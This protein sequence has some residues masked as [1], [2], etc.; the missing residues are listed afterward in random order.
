MKIK[1]YSF[2]G[3]EYQI[4]MPENIMYTDERFLAHFAVESTE[5]P[6]IFNFN[7][8]EELS[9]PMGQCVTAKPGFRIYSENNTYVRYIGSVEK[10]W[11]NAYIRAEHNGRT[12]NI[13][14]KKSQFADRVGTHTVLSALAAEH[15]IVQAGGVV[16]HCAYIEHNGKAILFT[17][18][19]ET[20]KSTQADLWN[21]YRKARII[22]GDRAAIRNV[23]GKIYACGIPF[24][25]SSN[26]CKNRTLPLAAIIYL[27]QASETT[28]E[29]L[30]GVFGFKRVWEGCT[31]NTWNQEDVNRAL[32]IVSDITT[33]VPV[34]LLQCTPDKSA[35]IALERKLKEI[36]NEE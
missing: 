20:G 21:K 3:V 8:C 2:A 25:G 6:H 4:S 10:N 22:N 31:I 29:K 36:E 19:S 13:Q 35:V 30:S 18:P 12:H 33:K 17:A 27:G 11:E 23:D 16:F 34:Y 7:Y 15:L 32:D 28:I 1:N 5:K 26:Y 24:A 9:P 14:L